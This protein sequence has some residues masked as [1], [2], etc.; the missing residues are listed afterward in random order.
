M[1]TS[2][3]H[4]YKCM[5]DRNLNATKLAIM[6]RN[7]SGCEGVEQQQNQER[8]AS[9][10][11]GLKLGGFWVVYDDP[12]GAFSTQSTPD[13]MAHS[14]AWFSFPVS[15]AAAA[16]HTLLIQRNYF[17]AIWSVGFFCK[18]FLSFT[19]FFYRTSR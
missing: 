18:G 7:R 1:L 13:F 11:G 2:L 3:C 12:A 10:C 5:W 6:L 14:P 4:L 16:P 19:V 17:Y 9:G 15:T 8:H